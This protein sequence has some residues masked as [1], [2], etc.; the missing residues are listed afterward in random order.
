MVKM[1]PDLVQAQAMAALVEKAVAGLA[2]AGTA[3]VEK[4]AGELEKA[5]VGRRHGG[6]GGRRVAVLGH[7]RDAGH[8]GP[9]CRGEG[10]LSCSDFFW[11]TETADYG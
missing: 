1:S 7:S 4:G 8:R 6:E 11:R 9:G 10:S 2:R 3:P 5:A